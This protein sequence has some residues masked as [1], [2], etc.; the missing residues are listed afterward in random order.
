MLDGFH[1]TYNIH[2]LVHITKPVHVPDVQL[3]VGEGESLQ[4]IAKSV[5]YPYIPKVVTE[6]EL[7]GQSYEYTQIDGFADP[8]KETDFP[9][10]GLFGDAIGGF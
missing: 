10:D 4:P 5:Q 8:I 2:A 7:A 9:K 1:K 3:A 6:P